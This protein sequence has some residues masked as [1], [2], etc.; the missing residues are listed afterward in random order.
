MSKGKL[1]LLKTILETDNQLKNNIDIKLYG[2]TKGTQGRLITVNRDITW[3][4]C[5]IMG[6]ASLIQRENMFLLR[7]YIS[8]KYGID[9]TS[10]EI[11]TMIEY[12]I[13]ADRSDLIESYEEE[14]IE[15]YKTL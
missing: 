13:P 3:D 1:A 14:S 2:F 10:L 8:Y 6:D 11:E 7:L 9:Y 5:K 15:G 12:L 4:N